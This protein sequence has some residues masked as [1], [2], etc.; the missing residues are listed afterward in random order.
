MRSSWGGS[1]WLCWPGLC[2]VAF[3]RSSCV[4]TAVMIRNE[5]QQTSRSMNGIMLISESTGFFPPLPP[6]STETPAIGS[7]R[8]RDRSQ[9]DL[10]AV[11]HDEVQDLD[12]GLVDVVVEPLRLAVEQRV[13]DERHEGD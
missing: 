5:M 9:V 2:C 11:V 1:C 3:S 7:R 8:R 4:Q 6:L 10:G 12:G 13:A